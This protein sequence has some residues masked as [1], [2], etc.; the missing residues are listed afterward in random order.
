MTGQ[1]P[2]QP[3]RI[4]QALRDLGA[5]PVG[6]VEGALRSLKNCERSASTPARS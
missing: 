6:A 2:L 4:P 5:R 1:H 3:E